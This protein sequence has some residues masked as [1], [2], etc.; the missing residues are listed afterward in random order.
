M[1]AKIIVRIFESLACGVF[2]T[3]LSRKEAKLYVLFW[4]GSG[5]MLSPAIRI[6][7]HKI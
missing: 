4:I 6:S 3:I 7:E 5:I 2:D 1:D